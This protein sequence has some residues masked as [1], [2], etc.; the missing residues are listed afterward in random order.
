MADELIETDFELN[1]QVFVPAS[2]GRGRAMSEFTVDYFG[3]E[4]G[5]IM[6]AV[7]MQDDA[8]L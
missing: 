6:R 2:D 1:E 4:V 7:K 5:V 3:G 8:H